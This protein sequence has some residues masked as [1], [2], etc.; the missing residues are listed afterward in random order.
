MGRALRGRHAPGRTE[1]DTAPRGED[2]DT[3]EEQTRASAR[4]D[5]TGRP[6]AAQRARGRTGS[7]LGQRRE[8][9][10]AVERGEFELHYQPVVDLATQPAR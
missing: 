4:R 2:G 6:P 10:T 1:A 7:Q 8:R 5:E 9:V 3:A